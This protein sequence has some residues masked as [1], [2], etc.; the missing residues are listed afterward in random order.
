MKKVGDGTPGRRRIRPGAG[1]ARPATSRT[2]AEEILTRAR[3]ERAQLEQ[4]RHFYAQLIDQAELL[5]EEIRALHEEQ[6]EVYR[7]LNNLRRRFTSLPPVPRPTG[8]PPITVAPA[9]QA[10]PRAGAGRATA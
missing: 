8:Y 9:T 7:Q 1:T 5:H 6:R 10:E 4:G 2:S 3:A